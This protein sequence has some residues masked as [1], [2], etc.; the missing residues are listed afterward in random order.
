MKKNKKPKNCN[1]CKELITTRNRNALYCSIE[2]CAA[3]NKH[4]YQLRKEK[5]TKIKMPKEPADFSKW[6][7]LY[8][9]LGM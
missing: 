5:T 3:S 6:H 9:D 4:K 8:D 2:C 1:W 7:D